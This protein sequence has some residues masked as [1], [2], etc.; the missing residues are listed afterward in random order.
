M[1]YRGTYALELGGLW[2]TH[3]KIFP[4]HMKF[5][6]VHMIKNLPSGIGSSVDSSV[7][8]IGLTGSKTESKH[9]DEKTSVARI[10][11]DRHFFQRIII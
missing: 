6:V 10:C 3:R 4:V 8:S 5:E 9:D 2:S 11:Y 1:K 7:G